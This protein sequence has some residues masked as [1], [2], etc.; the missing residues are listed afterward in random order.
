MG[1]LGLRK[2]FINIGGTLARQMTAV[3]LG[4]SLV[5][6]LARALGPQGNGTY[7]MTIL[8]PTLLANLL[9][10]GI[11]SANVYYIGRGSISVYHAFKTNIRLWL[12]L[13][14]LGVLLAV[15]VVWV[16]GEALFPGVPKIFLW[17]TS[18]LIFP[19]A[20]LQFLLT[21]LLQ[22]VQDFRRFNHVLLVAPAATLLLAVLTV[23]LF[24]L[25]V[26]GAL[27]AFGLGYFFGL[28]FSIY[29]VRTYL[30]DKSKS[31]PPPDY[32]G[33]CIG[34]G[35]KAHLS[36]ILTF[37][38]Y[39]TDIYL[40]NL[41][42]NPAFT[43]IYVIA[44]QIAERLWMLS[45]SVSTVILP[46]LSE[47]HR[48]EETRKRLTPI[49]ARWIFMVTV[50][51][52][53]TLALFASPLIKLLF[54]AKYLAAA[55]ALLWL[56]PGIAFTSFSRVLANDL[57]A[58]GRPDLNMYAACL[59]VIVNV[60]ANIVL[61]PRMGINGA[62]LATTIAYTV[63]AVVKFYLYARLSGN[64]L[65]QVIAFS[66]AD[67]EL[68]A[69]GI[70][71]FRKLFGGSLSAGQL[72]KS[73]NTNRRYK[74]CMDIFFS[75][76]FIIAALPLMVLIAMAIKF[77]TGAPAIFIQERAGLQGRPFKIYKFRTML[78]DFVST[79]QN[80][81]D[82]E[83]RITRV[84]RLLRST[85][86]DELPQLFNVL[87]GDMSLVGPRPT[88]LYQVE[89]YSDGQKKRLDVP[90]GM[91]GWTQ[92][93]RGECFSWEERI[94][95]DIHYIQ[96]WSLGLDFKILWMTAGVMLKKRVAWVD[97]SDDR[98]ARIP[99]DES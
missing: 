55:G 89:K 85:S 65:W 73:A 70:N 88:L 83:K 7:A 78:R 23:W 31:T 16:G 43:G 44:V 11:P 64:P 46:R 24:D 17:L 2:L 72:I 3:L 38:N 75:L 25:G 99:T 34:Y 86:L 27:T 6:L 90:P 94:K 51:A 95:M 79:G 47:L 13:S 10:L 61:I 36:N 15:L 87:K 92:V 67:R 97:Q 28:V 30:H 1:S 69:N 80:Y 57:A 8:L 50:V 18:L 45:Q 26:A 96:N 48:D 4:I 54:G 62:A 56:L 41:F 91:T 22:G 60:I 40:V 98:I 19:M 42:L 12:F 5:V 53:G 14:G 93:N 76:I 58:R 33:Q 82:E 77:E 81:A 52:G 39:R 20:L 68:L 66:R 35:W 49:V 59:V 84:G 37:I 63:N 32:A 29:A 9:N 21:S 74:R 71:S